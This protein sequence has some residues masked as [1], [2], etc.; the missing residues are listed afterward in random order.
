MHFKLA[1]DL[2]ALA[3]YLPNFTVLAGGHRWRKRAVQLARDVRRSPAQAKIV[4]DYHW[5]EMALS[6]HM[7]VVEQQGSLENAR[8]FTPDI[9]ALHFA[10]MVVEVF[11]RLTQSGRT[12]LQGRIRDSL[13]AESGFAALYFEMDMALRLMADG[14]EVDFPDLEGRARYD[15]EFSKGAIAGEV[16]CKSL[17]ADAGRKIHRKHFY[18][19]LET[20]SPVLIAAAEAGSDDVLVITLADRLPSDT[21]QQK[22]L[23]T[24]VECLCRNRSCSETS[25][26]FFII[27][28]ESYSS[29]LSAAPQDSERAF[30]NYCCHVFGKDVHI[31]GVMTEKGRCLIAMRSRAEDDHSR[32]WLEATLEAAHQFS[33]ARPSFIAV[34]LNDIAPSDLALP[35]VKRRAEIL[36]GG[37]FYREGTDHVAATFFSTYGSLV[38]IGNGLHAPAFSILNPKLKFNI[39]RD[40]FAPLIG[41]KLSDDEFAKILNASE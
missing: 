14:F 6:E 31:S 16:E 7:I 30:Y 36:S 5:L 12:A 11:G 29:R 20:V 9:A 40:A 21:R 17:S 25:G 26:D 19:F 15:L 1:T 18:R 28:R 34:Q 4:T 38:S 27:S 13:Q 32:P 39:E 35:H 10:G 22:P 24:A 37:L 8:L 3:A 33:R 23:R 41:G 2:P